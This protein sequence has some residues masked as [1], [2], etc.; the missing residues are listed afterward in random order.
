M[1]RIKVM[2]VDDSAFVRQ[3]LCAVLNSDN[4]IEVISTAADPIFA[5]RKIPVDL[6]DVITLDLEMPRMNGLTFLK[7][8]MS[9]FP[10]PV[11]VI[12]S[13]TEKSNELTHKAFEYGAIDVIT[14]PKLATKEFF[15]ESKILICDT[16]R[17]ASQARI[18]KAKKNKNN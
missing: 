13:L 3:S 17:A 7:K 2:I 16:V 4:G 11:V 15:D 6:P 1:R 5:A 9:E 10:M 8:I 18:I 12:S 14:K